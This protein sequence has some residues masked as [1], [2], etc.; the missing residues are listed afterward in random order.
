MFESTETYTYCPIE[1]AHDPLYYV[2]RYRCVLKPWNILLSK[3]SEDFYCVG[4]LP[5]FKD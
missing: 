3:M 1:G 4:V 5:D 2:I